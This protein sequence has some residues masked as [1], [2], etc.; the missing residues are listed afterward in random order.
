[1]EEKIT[2]N[3]LDFL[4][5]HYHAIREWIHKNDKDRAGLPDSN[6]MD[7]AF[8]HDADPEHREFLYQHFPKIRTWVHNNDKLVEELSTGYYYPRLMQVPYDDFL[9][10]EEWW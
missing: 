7:F 4:H 9:M 5:V 1:M 2:A 6:Y 3:Q 8:D 10:L